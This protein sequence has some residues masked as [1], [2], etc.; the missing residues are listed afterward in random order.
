MLVCFVCFEVT[1]KNWNIIFLKRQKVFQLWCLPTLPAF[2]IILTVEHF[3]LCV[4]LSCV[5]FWHPAQEKQPDLTCSKPA[6]AT[7][8]WTKFTV[9][10]NGEMM[11]G[12][13]SRG[14]KCYFHFTLV[15]IWEFHLSQSLAKTHSDDEAKI[16]LRIVLLLCLIMS[17]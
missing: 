13:E 6:L 3:C 16:N 17:L 2:F 7:V 12:W 10:S 4:H 9:L 14:K 15:V 5:C 8:E 11:K 1:L